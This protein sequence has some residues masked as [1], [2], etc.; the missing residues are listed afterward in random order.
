MGIGTIL[1]IGTVF[2]FLGV[3]IVCERIRYNMNRHWMEPSG[4]T[5]RS[6]SHH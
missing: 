2:A 6:D 5:K 4:P 3:L 1:L